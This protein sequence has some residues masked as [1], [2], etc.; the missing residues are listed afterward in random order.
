MQRF[1]PRRSRTSSHTECCRLKCSMKRNLGMNRLDFAIIWFFTHSLAHYNC[2]F[3]SHSDDGTE[4]EWYGNV[5]SVLNAGMLMLMRCER[6]DG[7]GYGKRIKKWSKR[8]SHLNTNEEP[9]SNGCNFKR[10]D[11]E[12]RRRRDTDGIKRL[13]SCPQ[14]V[15]SFASHALDLSSASG[16]SMG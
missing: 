10:R 15:K 8:I 1:G 6:C 12:R 2:Y 4:N 9:T 5:C 3:F 16:P 14:H 7:N 11:Q 13:L